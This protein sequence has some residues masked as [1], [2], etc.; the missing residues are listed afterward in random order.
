M[1]FVVGIIVCI[2]L[3]LNV[4]EFCSFAISSTSSNFIA[5][6]HKLLWRYLTSQK[7]GFFVPKKIC[8][9]ESF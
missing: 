8:F 2:A 1:A 9:L 5:P 4:Y 7:G 3:S 6:K